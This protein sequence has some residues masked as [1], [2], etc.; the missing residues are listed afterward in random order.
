M[1]LTGSSYIAGYKDNDTSRIAAENLKESDLRDMHHR[2]LEVLRRKP[3]GLNTKGIINYLWFEAIGAEK[4][5]TMHEYA[6]AY[7]NFDKYVRPRVTELFNH[8]L[9]EDSK[10][11]HEG[12]KVWRIATRAYEY[13]PHGQGVMFS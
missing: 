12:A 5:P 8:S 6:E 10:L 3:E 13:D 11:R 4:Y 7:N 1:Q 2:I 9:I